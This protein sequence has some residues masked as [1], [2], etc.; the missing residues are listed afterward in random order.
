MCT[1]RFLEAAHYW[2]PGVILGL[3]WLADRWNLGAFFVPGQ[4]L[5]C[6]TAQLLGAALVARWERTHSSRVMVSARPRESDDLYAV[7][8]RRQT[9]LQRDH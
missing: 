3:A 5:G 9:R 4:I 2:A 6:A 8:P 7:S 1:F